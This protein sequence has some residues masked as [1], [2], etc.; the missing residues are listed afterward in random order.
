MKNELMVLQTKEIRLATYKKAIEIIK[1]GKLKFGLSQH[2]LCLLLPSIL[3][4]L[5][6]YTS[7]APNNKCWLFLRAAD[8][9]PE[10]NEWLVVYK[11]NYT[12]DTEDTKDTGRLEY[13]NKWVKE[14]S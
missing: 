6:H 4:D 3:W 11:E 14:L 1:D 12:E 5:P 10:L 8:M 7:K 13:L 9:F 2:A